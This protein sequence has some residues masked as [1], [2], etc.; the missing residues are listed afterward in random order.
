MDVEQGFVE[1]AIAAR[2]AD[3]DEGDFEDLGPELPEEAGEGAGL[4]LGAANEDAFAGLGQGFLGVFGGS[5]L[6]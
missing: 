2:L 6:D 4:V 1:G 5:W 3:F